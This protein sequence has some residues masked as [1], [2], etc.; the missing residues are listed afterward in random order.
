[1]QALA[2]CRDQLQ[3]LGPGVFAHC[4]ALTRLDA[5]Q[6]ADQPLGNPVTPAD[7][8]GDLLLGPFRRFQVKIRAPELS[9]QL[10]DMGFDGLGDTPGKLPEIL[11]EDVVITQKPIETIAIANRSECST[12]ENAVKAGKDTDH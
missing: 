12:K 9:D 6:D 7:L 8:L 4:E 10:L 5:A 11:V 3:L 2:F 1:M